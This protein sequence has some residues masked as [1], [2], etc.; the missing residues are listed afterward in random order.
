MTFM[1][2]FLVPFPSESEYLSPLPNHVLHSYQRHK[3]ARAGT[4]KAYRLEI[5]DEPFLRK[6]SVRKTWLLDYFIRHTNITRI[7][8]LV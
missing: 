3:E 6:N 4:S 1:P 2:P 7:K 8:N 5:I